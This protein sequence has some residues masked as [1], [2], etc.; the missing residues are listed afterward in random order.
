MIAAPPVGES[1]AV[2]GKIFRAEL[3]ITTGLK[4]VNEALVQP[5][6]GTILAVDDRPRNLDL[7]NATLT[8]EGYEV[9]SAADGPAALER[10]AL[11]MPDLILLDVMMPGMDGYEVCRRLKLDPRTSEVAVIFLSAATDKESVVKG[12][13]AG[14]VDYVTK[15]FAKAELIARVNTHVTLRH[16]LDHNHRLLQERQQR[17]TE[18][19]DNIKR[20]LRAIA[21]GL[22]ELQQL[23]QPVGTSVAS[24][25]ND[26]LRLANDALAL[27]NQDFESSQRTA[28]Q[29]S[30]APFTVTSDTLIE[31]IGK[32]YV[33]AHNRRIEF[34]IR[35]P[36]QVVSIACRLSQLDYLVSLLM[37]A[38]LNASETGDAIE[39]HFQQ[40]SNVLEVFIAYATQAE[41]MR[42]PTDREEIQW[43]Q[44]SAAEDTLK[45]EAERV[46]AIVRLGTCATG[47]KLLALVLP[48]H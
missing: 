30:N 28:D 23:L 25:L 17:L 24:H 4:P 21:Q 12:I 20:P 40:V 22:D 47:V 39:V 48:V 33:S 31:L 27:L 41:T 10:L 11:K 34:K 3:A 16:L 5:R 14:G 13:E 9:I 38:A 46:G 18:E 6:K 19:V 35:R 42:M 36:S 44:P 26:M 45:R 32:W 29:E 1:E 15:P 37:A 43:S 8:D 7:I 2:L